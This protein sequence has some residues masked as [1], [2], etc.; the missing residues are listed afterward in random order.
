MAVDLELH[1]HIISA[2]KMT[3]IHRLVENSVI[4]AR[5]IRIGT[6]SAN[7][8]LQAQDDLAVRHDALVAALLGDDPDAAER[9]GRDHIRDAMQRLL[10][11][12]E[13]TRQTEH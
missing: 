1:M 10:A 4:I 6:T 13:E 11:P 8:P 5:A 2:S 7:K 12:L 3:S 9:A